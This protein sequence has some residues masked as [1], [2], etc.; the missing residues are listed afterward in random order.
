MSLNPPIYALLK[1]DATVQGL[2]G[3][4]EPRVY[5][6][7]EAPQEGARPY[8]TWQV[9]SAVPLSLLDGPPP[10]DQYRVQVDSWAATRAEAHQ[11]ATAI[12]DVLEQVGYLVGIQLDERDPDTRLWRIA[13]D[14]TVWTDR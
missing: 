6:S 11:V 7:G 5:P 9:V 2:L 14:F 8:A 13:L 3:G 4:A 12:R 1:A 10:M